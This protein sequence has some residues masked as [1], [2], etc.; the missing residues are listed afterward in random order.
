MYYLPGA[1]NFALFDSFMVDIDYPRRS[2]KLWIFQVTKS[3]LHRGSAK[4]YPLVRK[5]VSILKK[6]LKGEREPP[7]KTARTRSQQTPSNP[8]VKV[9]Y[10][11]VVPKDGPRNREWQFPIGWEE[12]CQN[13]DHRP[14]VR[15]SA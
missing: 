4:G 5:L 14:G 10:V 15:C 12:G 1:T 8:D 9:C 13:D 2:A 3:Q 6:Q 11:L 7:L